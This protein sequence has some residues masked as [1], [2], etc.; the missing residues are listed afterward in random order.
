MKWTVNKQ[1][2][3]IKELWEIADPDFSQS[4]LFSYHE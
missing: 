3:G 2:H 4:D 1:T